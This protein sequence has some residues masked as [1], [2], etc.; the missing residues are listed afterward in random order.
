MALWL[1]RSGSHGEY[2]KQFLDDKKIY[3]QWSHLEA[4]LAKPPSKDEMFA[5]LREFYP[6]EGTDRVWTWT[7][8]AWQFSKEMQ[9]NDWVVMPSK[10]KPAIHFARITGAYKY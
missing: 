9:I 2:E 5:L 4:D 7:R 8:Q 3:F 1:V 6:R 10:L